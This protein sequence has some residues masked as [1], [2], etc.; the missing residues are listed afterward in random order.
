ML[1]IALVCITLWNLSRFAI[2]MT[3]KRELVALL[4]LYFG[5]RVTVNVL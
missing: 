1:V 2:I 4:L 5:C 3:R